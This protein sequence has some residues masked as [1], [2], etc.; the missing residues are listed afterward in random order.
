MN[1]ALKHRPREFSDV[2]GQK[3]TSVVLQAMI[4]KDALSSVLLFTGPSGVGK[5]SMARIIAAQLNSEAAVA[6]HEGTHPAVLEIDA[7][8][9]GSVAALRQ[10][11]KDLNYAIAGH[12]VV[13]LDEAHAISS[14]GKAV[15]LNLLEFP[16]DNVTFI[17]LTTEPHRI[18][19]EVRHRCDTYKF[20]K[21]SIFDLSMRLQDVAEKEGIV[22][23]SD[24]LNL[25]AQRAE[26]SFRESLMILNQVWVGNVTTVSEYNSL[27]GE[28]DFGP[29]VIKSC[30]NGPVSALDHLK[31]LLFYVPAE[32][33]RDRIVETLADLLVLKSGNGLD[34][35][36]ESLESRVF[37][38][39]KLD[40]MRIL[41]AIRIMWDLQTKLGAGDV[42]RGLEMALSLIGEAVGT[43][44][45]EDFGKITTSV[46]SAPLSFE[47]MKNMRS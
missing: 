3:A 19:K 46:K 47:Q 37:L 1:L 16:P 14:E 5:T 26:G 7:A 30:L 12:R 23:D 39:S 17:L 38:A 36:G 43:V 42:V 29:G 20:Q 18:P 10:L 9:N 31:N 4:Q 28:F 27:H 45:T 40:Q 6:V 8:S 22:V 13:I 34:C 2:V 25:I 15:L 24:L 33:I 41:K 11:K 35:A 21:A 32:D 44:P